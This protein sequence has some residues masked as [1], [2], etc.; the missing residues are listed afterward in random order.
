MAYQYADYSSRSQRLINAGQQ[1]IR[2]LEDETID[3]SIAIQDVESAAQASTASELV[4]RYASGSDDSRRSPAKISAEDAL[5]GVLLD[6]QAANVLLSAGVALNE[7]GRGSETS[8]LYD[9]MAEVGN[10]QAIVMHNLGTRARREFSPASG[11]KSSTLQA[12]KKTFSDNAEGVLK[13]IVDEAAGVV[14]DVLEKL[15]KFDGA[16]V[17]E[18]IQ[19]LGESFQV[20]SAAGKL[21][22]RG[23]D[24]LKNALD[25]LSKLF[26]GK[27][28]AS[29]KGKVAEIWK[30]CQSGEYTRDV[31]KRIFDVKA[32]EVHIEGILAQADL[33]IAAIDGA[34]NDLPELA[35]KFKG[36]MKLFR[37]LMSGVALAGGI[38][39]FLQLAAPWIPL[40][41]AGVYISLIAAAVLVGMDYSDSGRILRW[42]RGVGEIANS[43]K[44]GPVKP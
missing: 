38:I 39:A 20:I 22:K 16:K 34:T 32:T 37:S 7:H 3:R 9:S 19:K 44:P 12:A 18:S 10:S 13:D 8:F 15:R 31:L 26:G 42:V 1:L 11:I 41:M 24:L 43:I 27:V 5:S 30:Q 35:D 23:L 40:A 14:A 2:S 29:A 36:N 28:L 33:D 17:T 6:V 21:I 25:A 4:L